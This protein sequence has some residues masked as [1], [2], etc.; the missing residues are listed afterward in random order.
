MVE[1]RE[2]TLCV[3]VED[4]GVGMDNRKKSELEEYISRP[5]TNPGGYEQGSIGVRNVHRRIRLAC[6]EPYGITIESEPYRGSSFLITFP[7]RRKGEE[8]CTD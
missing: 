4:D 2:E 6:G 7:L 3:R 8:E 5:E 1:S